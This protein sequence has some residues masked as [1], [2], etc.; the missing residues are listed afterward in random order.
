MKRDSGI[1]DDMTHVVKVT[2]T[3]TRERPSFSHVLTAPKACRRA[4]RGATTASK[5]SLSGKEVRTRYR[6]L[7]DV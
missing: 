5:V 7:Q 2:G 6:A 3:S 1:I 4:S